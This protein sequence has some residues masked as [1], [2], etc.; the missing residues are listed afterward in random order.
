MK[1]SW[2]IVLCTSAIATSANAAYTASIT[3]NG[4]ATDWNTTPTPQYSF[5]DRTEDTIDD[6][7]DL[8]RTWIANECA[9]SCRPRYWD[10][11]RRT[12]NV[13]LG[14]R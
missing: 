9:L 2:L 4:N 12:G 3:V 7:R 10:F 6:S 1:L 5:R 14:G 13:P 11:A 8:V